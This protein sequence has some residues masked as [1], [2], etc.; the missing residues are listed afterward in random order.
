MPSI[1]SAILLLRS[2][3]LRG[4]PDIFLT[5]QKKNRQDR[6]FE[7]SL[8]DQGPN[9]PGKLLEARLEGNT[10]RVRYTHASL[11][12][13]YLAENLLRLTWQP[14]K[15]P[16]PYA[17]ARSDWPACECQLEDSRS[18]PVFC[19][20]RLALHLNEQ[21]GWRLCD[22]AGQ[23]LRDE[24]PAEFFTGLG[25]AVRWSSRARLDEGEVLCGLGLHSGGL[26]LRGRGYSL[27][28]SDPGGQHDA[29]SDPLYLPLPVFLSLRPAGSSL[30][31]FENS[32]R[33]RFELDSPTAPGMAQASFDGGALR[34]YL[35]AGTPEELLE[36]FSQL[37]GRPALPPRWSLGYQQSRWGYKSAEQIRQVV[38]GFQ[39]H[40]LP[41]QA[42]H[43]DIDY[44]DGYRVFTVDRQR[45]PDLKGLADEL[46]AQG[47][48]LVTIIDPGVKL[49]PGWSLYQNG[50]AQKVYVFD[51]DGQPQTG[52]VWPGRTVFPDFTRP[53]TRTWWGEQYRT[54][55]DQGVDGIWHDMNEPASFAMR[56]EMTLPLS[57]RH[58]LEGQGGNHL[59]AHNLY[60]F[61]MNR[62]AFKGWLHLAPERRPWIVSRSG[63]VG[64]AR[65][66]WNWTA[67]IAST[68]EGLA[69][70][71]RSLLNMGLAGLP[72]TG[73]DIGGFSGNP[74][75]ELYLR[76]LQ[77]AC[78]SAFMRTHSAIG[79]APREPWVFGEPYTSAV[80]Q[81]LRLR[82]R[83]LPYLYSQA[84]QAARRGWPLMRPLFFHF[85][86][87]HDL[88]A[89]EDA[90]L[91]G[92]CLLVG[93]ALAP[94]LSQRTVRLP[95]GTWFDFWSDQPLHGPGEV[96]LPVELERFPLLVHSPAVLPLETDG[97]LELHL[98]CDA[99]L[100]PEDQSVP[101]GFQYLDAGDGPTDAP[102][103][104]IEFYLQR[105]G[106]RLRLS[107]KTHGA[108]ASPY[109]KVRLIP[110]GFGWQSAALDGQPQPGGARLETHLPFPSITFELAAG[111][112]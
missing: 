9:Q 27:W 76:W 46:H 79:T 69:T 33:A 29:A 41:L 13:V 96:E 36:R 4:L 12:A 73:S 39:A 48:R 107:T 105:Q 56:G 50:Y 38:A 93:P 44:L 35:I 55:L 20:A 15:L 16:T 95:E 89:R 82:Q 63:W 17:I 23:L 74:T 3:G 52:V 104:E 11:E 108:F 28:N 102:F 51:Q 65:Y 68:W 1:F 85:P 64:N 91:C 49:D 92:D 111:Q 22:L 53:A 87:E 14:G 25:E 19:S 94:G 26:N 106:D 109:S 31:F 100:L 10:L 75:P 34:C 80:R 70:T 58:D 77:M 24:L 18:K 81:T 72:F 2:L 57:A 67:D 43:L 54:L 8:P 32:T 42:I 88:W 47:V 30:I 78:F 90:F 21:G 62:A 112:L 61:Q 98:Y 37:T 5:D 66:A 40:D 45:F 71:L 60:G 83:L 97:D 99:N 7:R 86:A 110:H 101:A 84:R 59:E 103:L 6:Q